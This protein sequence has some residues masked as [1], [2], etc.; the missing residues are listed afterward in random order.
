M[1][2]ESAAREIAVEVPKRLK[3][4][5]DPDW[6]DVVLFGITGTIQESVGKL[7]RE[8][9]TYAMSYDDSQSLDELSEYLEAHE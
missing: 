6:D 3:W 8:A 4:P 1:L 2:T 9:S 7:A 5:N